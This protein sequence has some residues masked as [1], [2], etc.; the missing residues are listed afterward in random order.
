MQENK[1]RLSFFSWIKAYPKKFMILLFLILIPV[2]L[3]TIL[4]I[5]YNNKSTRFHFDDVISDNINYYYQ[6]DVNS[7]SD[8]DTYFKK[9]D[10]VFDELTISKVDGETLEIYKFN[11][12]VE[13][14]NSYAGSRIDYKLVLATDYYDKQSSIYTRANSTNF[15]MTLDYPFSSLENKT[16]LLFFKSGKPNLY[17]KV[18]LSNIPSSNPVPLENIDLVFKLDLNKSTGY[19]VID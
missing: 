6:K 5:S 14:N 7:K 1:K 11:I 2:L 18:T 15:T 19:S 8:F 10:V 16:K 9:F 3:I 13:L 4:T 17:I 12:N